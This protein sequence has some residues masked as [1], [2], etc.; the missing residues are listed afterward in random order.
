MQDATVIALDLGAT[1]CAAGII[2]YDADQNDYACTT[3]CHVKLLKTTSFDDLIKQ[4]ES[5]LGLAFKDADAICIGAAGQYTGSELHHLDGVYPYPMTIAEQAKKEGWRDYAVI[6]D[7]D[8]VVCAT[9]TSYMNNENN[10]QRINSCNVH[11]FKRRVAL[12]LG[13]GLGLKDGVLFENGDFWLGKNEIGHIGIVSPPTTHAAFI[14]RH[15]E[16]M[17]FM[18]QQKTMASHQPV[19]FENILTGRGLLY[20]HNFLY[21]QTAS[22]PEE[23]GHKIN[24]GEASELIDLYAWYLGLFIGTVQL[25]FMP[26]G[27]IWM[28]GGVALSNLV[29][30]DNPH[31]QEGIKASPA[32]ASERAEQAI[33]ILKNP[34]HALI[35]AGYYAVQRL[36]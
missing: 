35:G 4:I 5:Q 32:Y 19:T 17:Q 24:A 33:G 9:F 27:G 18:R 7:Y 6:H 29:I 25:T 20:C 31:L 23:V 3:D 12:G 15:R 22:T 16:L 2:Q 21:S 1:K 30:F 8:T 11:P 28:T 13:T 10:I 36:L 34:Q 14:L 26:E